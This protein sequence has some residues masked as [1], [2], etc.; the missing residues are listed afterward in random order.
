MF[1]QGFLGIENMPY[2]DLFRFMFNNL[3]IAAAFSDYLGCIYR[4]FTAF[5]GG[6]FIDVWCSEDFAEEVFEDFRLSMGI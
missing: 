5:K 1:A 4:E 2:G 6:L 3:Y